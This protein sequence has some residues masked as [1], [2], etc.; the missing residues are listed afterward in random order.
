MSDTRKCNFLTTFSFNESLG[1]FIIYQ[2]PKNPVNFLLKPLIPRCLI[3]RFKKI[4]CPTEIC[5]ISRMC[6]DENIS[7]TRKK[8]I[9][10]L[11]VLNIC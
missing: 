1:I 9:V 3:F 2:N 10:L 8:V 4:V 5:Q 7:K 6:V 11:K